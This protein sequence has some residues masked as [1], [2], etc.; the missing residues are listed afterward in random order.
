MKNWRNIIVFFM[1]ISL[2]AQS[3]VAMTPLSDNDLSKVSGAPAWA[4]R[5]K[6][7]FPSSKIDTS[8]VDKLLKDQQKIKEKYIQDCAAK[9]IKPEPGIAGPCSIA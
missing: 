5:P 4:N 3:C 2:C 8:N 9:G 7:N 1:L 6:S